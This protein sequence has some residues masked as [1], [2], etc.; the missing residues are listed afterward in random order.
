MSDDAVLALPPAAPPARPRVL[1]VGTA[2]AAVATLMAFAGVIGLYLAERASVLSQ[3]GTWLPEGTSIPLT[4][5]GIAMATMLLSAV[6]MWWAVDAVGRNDRPAA[7][8]ALALTMMFGLAVINAISFLYT[9]ME[10]PVASVPGV[11]IYTITGGFIATLVAAMAYAAV[12]TFRTLGGEYHGRD[13]E[14]L[15]AAALFWYANIAVFA[16]IWY[17]IF[18][19]K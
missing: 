16:V 4:P 3:G 12:M 10:L 15:V 9:Q 17:A 11:F 1:L 19:T 6:T 13:R 8:L 5:G 7:Y 14:G 2:L 18:V